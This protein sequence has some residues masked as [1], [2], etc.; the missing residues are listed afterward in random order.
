[1][2]VVSPSRSDYLVRSRS[3]AGSVWPTHSE[4]VGPSGCASRGECTESAANR[5]IGSAVTLASCGQFGSECP[6]SAPSSVTGRSI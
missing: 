1:M 5:R 4:C 2:Q 3:G 6:G